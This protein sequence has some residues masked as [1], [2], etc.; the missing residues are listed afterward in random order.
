MTLR[1]LIGILYF[2]CEFEIWETID[3]DDVCVA[4]DEDDLEEWLDREVEMQ[5]IV[6]NRRK[7]IMRY[8]LAP[9]RCDYVR[10]L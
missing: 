2:A 8:Y 10:E 4:N 7:K 1:D 3:G 5:D 6:V 9:R